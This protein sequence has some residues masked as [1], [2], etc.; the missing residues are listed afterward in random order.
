MNGIVLILLVMGGIIGLYILTYYLN[1]KTEPPLD[2][3]PEV[4]CS[5]CALHGRCSLKAY[6]RDQCAEIREEVEHA[7]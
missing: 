6:S 7:E 1:S 2:I 3:D 5:S 4:G